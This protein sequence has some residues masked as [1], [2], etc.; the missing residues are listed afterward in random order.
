MTR[1]RDTFPV[2]V[3]DLVF[4]GEVVFLVGAIIVTLLQTDHMPKSVIKIPTDYEASEV[5]S[6]PILVIFYYLERCGFEV[7]VPRHYPLTA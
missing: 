5:Y 1:A 2:D 4:E 7:T 3:D 6:D